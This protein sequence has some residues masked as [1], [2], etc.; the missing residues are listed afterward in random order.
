MV[1]NAARKYEEQEQEQEQTI[2]VDQPQVDSQPVR[3]SRFERLMLVVGSAVTLLLIITLLSTKV[4]INNRQ[5][6]LQD[7]QSRVARVKNNNA[8]DR[9]EIA[10]LTSQGSLKKIAQKYGLSDKNSNVRNVNK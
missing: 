6:E 4:S 8:S 5:H 3:W 1:S 9:Q 10:D 2:Y 7:L